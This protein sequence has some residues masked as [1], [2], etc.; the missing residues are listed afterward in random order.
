MKTTGLKSADVDGDPALRPWRVVGT[1]RV[2]ALRREA[3][4][5]P[6][7][8][9][10]GGT[11]VRRADF[12]GRSER[13]IIGRCIEGYRRPFAHA[14]LDLPVVTGLRGMNGRA[15]GPAG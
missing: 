9:L 5:K 6:A 8:R 1:G 13:R 4:L 14:G 7:A 3:S 11:L 15:G 10:S 2:Q 12:G